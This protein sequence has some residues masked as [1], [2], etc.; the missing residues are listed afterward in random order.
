MPLVSIIVPCY[1]H[2]K[3]VE[4]TIESI[5]NQTYENIELIVIDDGSKDRSSEI[6][7]RLSKKYNFYF[8]H[9]VNAGL[10]ITLNKAIKMCKGKYVSICASDDKYAFNK[11]E[12]QVRLMEQHEEYGMC[13]SNVYIFTDEGNVQARRLQNPEEGWVFDKIFNASFF[14]Q[15]VSCFYK[16]NVLLELGGFDEN[17][18][19][20]DTDLHLRL[21]SRYQVGYID[22]FLA[23]YRVHDNNTVNNK[24]MILKEVLKILDKWKDHPDYQEARKKH[25][26]LHFKGLVIDNKKEAL[27]LLPE[28]V[29]FL[30]KKE[31]IKSIILL[32]LPRRV[33]YYIKA[34]IK[35]EYN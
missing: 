31:M 11:I 3:Y 10:S 14:M 29:S 8:E 17:L 6:L 19:V 32:V 9:Q 28:L 35:N 23:Y 20:E 21:T 2:E 27:K 24:V 12:A 13:Y 33:I 16:K 15:A 5:A 1:N 18:K 30:S 22:D 26:L 25:I 4:E 34:Y 7:E